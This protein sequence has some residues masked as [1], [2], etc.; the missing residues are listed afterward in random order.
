MKMTEMV[1]WHRLER[2]LYHDPDTSINPD[3]D[4]LSKHTDPQS[5]S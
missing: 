5:Y 3:N 2:S 4:D 1:N